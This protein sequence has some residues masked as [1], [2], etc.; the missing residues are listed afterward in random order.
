MGNQY[1]NAGYNE[2]AVAFWSEPP[3]LVYCGDSVV[4]ADNDETCDAGEG[5]MNQYSACNDEC[6]CNDGFAFNEELGQCLCTAVDEGAT[7][8]AIETS[9][10]QGDANDVTV[11]VSV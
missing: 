1:I 3:E 10:V 8:D 5:N 6:R 11:A 2:N 9:S 4:Q 7:I